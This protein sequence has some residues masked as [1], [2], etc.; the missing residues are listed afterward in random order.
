MALGEQVRGVGD[1]EAGDIARI[2]RE[3]ILLKLFAA[4]DALIAAVEQLSKLGSLAPHT[5][6]GAAQDTIMEWLEAYRKIPAMD[7]TDGAGYD[8]NDPVEEVLARLDG[9]FGVGQAANTISTDDKE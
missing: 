6:F 3:A 8:R 5:T 2:E 4:A 1:V 7:R 9:M